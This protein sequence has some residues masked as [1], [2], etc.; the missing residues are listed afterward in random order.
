MRGSRLLSAVAVV[1]VL[2]GTSA[3]GGQD[4]LTKADYVEQVADTLQNGGYDADQAEC[5]ATLVVDELGVERLK[6]VELTADT[7]EGDLQDLITA[8]AVA[9]AD[10]CDLPGRGG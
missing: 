6:D 1:G 2:V 9:A 4:D 8:A 3:C 7:P 10:E 5:V